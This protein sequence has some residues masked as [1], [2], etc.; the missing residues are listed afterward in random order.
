MAIPDPVAA[1]A[2]ECAR[3]GAS[4]LALADNNADALEKAKND[5]QAS[6]SDVKVITTQL[7]VTSSKAVDEW[8]ASAVEQFGAID[9]ACNIAGIEAQ[10][11]KPSKGNIADMTDEFWHSLQNVNV[12]GVFYCV[13]AQI[14]AM[15]KGGSI[16]NASSIAGLRGGEGKFQGSKSRSE[17]WTIDSQQVWLRTRPASMP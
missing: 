17:T 11:G 7:D 12:N 15:K 9:G 4:G 1:T 10:P 6:F 3:R 2:Q 8:I 5:L 14:R 13:R 16:V